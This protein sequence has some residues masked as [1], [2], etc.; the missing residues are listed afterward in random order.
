MPSNSKKNKKKSKSKNSNSS[1]KSNTI[2]QE[3]HAAVFDESEDY[4]TSRVIKRAP[5]GDVIVE[6]MSTNDKANKKKKNDK[7]DEATVAGGVS[8]MAN[9][10][11]LHWESLSANEKKEILRIDKNDVFNIIQMMHTEN[12]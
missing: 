1:K 12:S 2:S 6:S 5:N 10:L 8:R 3:I 4:P 11:D 7:K 9:V